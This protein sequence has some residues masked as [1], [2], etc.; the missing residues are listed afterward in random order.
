MLWM[1]FFA[2]C[3]G[4]SVSHL[5]AGGDRHPAFESFYAAHIR[6]L[7]LVEGATRYAAKANYH[8]AR[9]A[10]LIRLCPDAKFLIPIRAPAAHIASLLRQHRWFSAVRPKH[11]RALAFMQRSVHFEFGPERW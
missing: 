5:P 7:L 1:A 9:L 10:Y 4:P 3:D 2:R 8:V 11:P 6:K